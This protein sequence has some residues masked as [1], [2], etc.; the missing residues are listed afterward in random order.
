MIFSGAC[1]LCLFG[2]LSFK[3]TS[4]IPKNPKSMSARYMS[5]GSK[6]PFYPLFGCHDSPLSSGHV[7]N[8]PKRS[9]R[10]ASCISFSWH[11]K[12][13]IYS[14]MCLL[15]GAF[16]LKP[17]FFHSFWC[18]FF[19]QEA[20]DDHMKRQMSAEVR[21]STCCSLP[22]V[23]PP[24]RLFES[25]LRQM[26]ARALPPMWR[27]LPLRSRTCT[28]QPGTRRSSLCWLCMRQIS[29]QP[30][31]SKIRLH[32]FITDGFFQKL[33]RSLVDSSGE[34]QEFLKNN[35]QKKTDIPK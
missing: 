33:A 10:I 28:S 21:S 2:H 19:C 14:T 13:H 29:S 22:R 5:G 31:A 4:S 23:Q 35:D 32:R 25:H 9:Q 20:G 1:D 17:S 24:F 27:H 30:K 7:F 16:E 12:L 18:V 3:L 8:I 26:S 6:W 11:C 15:V 34:G